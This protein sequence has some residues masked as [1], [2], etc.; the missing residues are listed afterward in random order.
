MSTCRVCGHSGNGNSFTAREMMFGLRDEFDYFECSGCGCVQI[1]EIPGDLMK[2][3]PDQYYSFQ[4]PRLPDEGFIKS[5]AR[6]QRARYSLHGKGL[7]GRLLSK[8]YGIPDYYQW[9]KRAK[10]GF[11]SKILEI[12]SGTGGLLIVLNREGFTNLVGADPYIERDISYKSGVKVQKKHTSQIDERFDFVMMHHS[13]EHMP[14]SLSAMKELHRLL[15]PDRYAL[16]RIPVAGSYAWR[17]YGVNWVQLDPPRHL[18]LH[19]TKSIELL[20]RRAGLNV[21]EVVFDS[22]EFQFW[23]SEQYLKDIPLTDPKSHFVNPDRSA[24][25][26]G[27]IRS[28][29]NMA[30][31]LNRKRDGDQACF[32]LYK[33]LDSV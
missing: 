33:P 19:T 4:N 9:F 5:L 16:V 3:Y 20:A 22:F 21:A 30:A 8:V 2:Y 23:G 31:D 18:F 12:G 17:K 6:R 29:R 28:Y 7:I 1:R 15:E 13:F 26:Q 32:Y 27:Q 24:F 25:T 10:V 11:D 14:D